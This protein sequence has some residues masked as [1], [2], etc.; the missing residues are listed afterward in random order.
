MML[1]IIHIGPLAIQLPGL[2]LLAGVWLGTAATDSQ[3]GRLRLSRATLQNLI[4]F[5]LV[6]GVLGARLG[7]AARFL[8]VYA[9]NPLGLFSLQPATLSPGA[10]LIAG[11][12]A[13]WVYGQR[14]R[15]P[16]WATADA[17]AP[18][19]A[20]FSLST[21]MAH[22]A[23]GDAFGAPARVPWAVELWG[24]MRHP[25]QIYEILFAGLALMV[26]LEMGRRQTFPGCVSL[27]WVALASASRLF[28]EAFRGD[29]VLLIGG[30]RSA[31]IL[32][33]MTLL[34]ALA[35]M[36]SLATASSRAASP[37]RGA[38]ISD[39]IECL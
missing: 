7:Y 28:L 34:A 4:L 29:S 20:V 1:P 37:A 14:K 32:A 3:A 39:G 27:V 23:S 15:L 8:N 10:G 2:L 26:I 38:R 17:L 5:G 19:L 18:G 12:L 30:I 31:Q 22:L 24:D 36:R 25:S 13:C 35:L 33:L 6:S 9:E 21:G 11:L 16:F